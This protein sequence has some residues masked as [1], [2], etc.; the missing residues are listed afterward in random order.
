MYLALLNDQFGHLSLRKNR[1]MFET[2]DYTKLSQEEL[3][4]EEKK[5]KKGEF[6]S[7]GLIGFLIGI[8]GY[9]IVTKGIGFLHIALPLVLISVLYKGSQVQKMNLKHVQA[10]MKNRD[11]Q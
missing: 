4:T 3:L 7:A 5:L 1:N 10:E 2:K 9:G 6:F 11:V 8:L